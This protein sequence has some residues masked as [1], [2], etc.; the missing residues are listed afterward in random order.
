MNIE[1]LKLILEAVKAAGEGAFIIA[2]LY[3]VKGFLTYLIGWVC[4]TFAVIFSVKVITKGCVAANEDT[5]LINK[6]GRILDLNVYSERG[7][8]QDKI[9]ELKRQVEKC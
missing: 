3:L 1:E 4:G 2:I 5:D 6:I 8:I 9:A 7:E